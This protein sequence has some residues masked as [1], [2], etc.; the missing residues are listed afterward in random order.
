MFYIAILALVFAAIA[1]A[2]RRM[3]KAERDAYPAKLEAYE[4]SNRYGI[5]RPAAP[6]EGVVPALTAVVAVF[7]V[8]AALFF[9]LSITTV[10]SANQ[11]G[12]PTTFGKV[13]QPVQSGINVTSPFTKV[14]KLPT[15]P[16][17]VELTDED[18]VRAATSQAG[19]YTV[20]IS[21][22]WATDRN[23]ANKLYLQARTGD[24]DKIS[25]DIVAK[26]LRQAVNDVYA[27][28]TNVD[29]NE[30]RAEISALVNKRLSALMLSYGI[31]ITDVNLRSSVPDD[32]TKAAIASFAAEQQK[33][34]VAQQAK[35][36]AEAEAASRLATANGVRDAAN[37]TKNLSPE[38]Q[39]SAC[40]AATERA[41]KVAA[42]KG[43]SVYVP[44]CG[45]SAGT[46]VIVNQK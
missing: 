17:T 9:G 3:A 2:F 41:I 6:E 21:T 40:L 13:G 18:A 22:R 11:V 38:A 15:R 20:E 34:K 19:S 46:P 5:T 33:T 14:N 27:G 32:A 23:N 4:S 12:V 30:R 37:A 36:T 31:E 7:G 24:E 26:S 10:V 16:V 35:L 45:N 25:K 44:L 39:A 8:L 42:D 43:I 29:A 28:F 1:L